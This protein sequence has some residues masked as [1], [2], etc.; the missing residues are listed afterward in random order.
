[1]IFV[2]LSLCFRTVDKT[3]LRWYTKIF[4][5]APMRSSPHLTKQKFTNAQKIILG[6]LTHKMGDLLVL[7]LVTKDVPYP[8]TKVYAERGVGTVDEIFGKLDEM[9]CS[10]KGLKDGKHFYV[11]DNRFISRDR[12]E[13]GGLAVNNKGKRKNEDRGKVGTIMNFKRK[14]EEVVK[15]GG[16]NFKV[17][18]KN[19]RR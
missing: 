18:R 4:V 7:K 17:G 14:K 9:Y 1:M 19:K 13:S 6:T 16:Y 8:N 2:P 10:V 11:E 3:S 15:D 5:L 12:L